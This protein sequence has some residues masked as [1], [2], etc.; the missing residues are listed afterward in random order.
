MGK[1][2][3]AEN[4]LLCYSFTKRSN[5]VSI[6]LANPVNICSSVPVLSRTQCI[7]LYAYTEAQQQTYME[8]CVLNICID[9]GENHDG[10]AGLFFNQPQ[11]TERL[12]SG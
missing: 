11:R 6:M 12:E 10:S 7:Q 8:G 9:R 1:E 5:I 2:S 4:V 3:F